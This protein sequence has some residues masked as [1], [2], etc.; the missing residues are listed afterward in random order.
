LA[1]DSVS[2][3]FQNYLKTQSCNELSTL[4]KKPLRSQ[5]I[6]RSAPAFLSKSDQIKNDFHIKNNCETKSFASSFFS[7]EPEMIVLDIESKDLFKN[8]SSDLTLNLMKITSQRAD[9]ISKVNLGISLLYSE[10]EPEIISETE[11]RTET[12]IE[13]V[14]FEWQKAANEGVLNR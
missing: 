11:L 12:R 9:Q 8:L 7:L 2:T 5:N 14:P 1:R 10:N 3:L 13:Q 4:P 6:A